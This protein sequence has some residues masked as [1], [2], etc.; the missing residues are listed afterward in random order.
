MIAK[1]RRYIS[2]LNSMGSGNGE[3][4]PKLIPESRVVE[5]SGKGWGWVWNRPTGVILQRGKD[6][7]RYPIFDF[8]RALQLLFY[9]ISLIF[10]AV[11]VSVFL[12][13]DK[14]D[15]DGGEE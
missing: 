13:I 8:T 6:Q 1:D 12:R 14:G 11:G 4:W 15:Q 3:N 9:G 5:L 10:I 7:R 2:L